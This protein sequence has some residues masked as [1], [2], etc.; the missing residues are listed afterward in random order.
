[1]RPDQKHRPSQRQALGFSQRRRPRSSSL[2]QR[3]D[4]NAKQGRPDGGYLSGSR[5]CHNGSSCHVCPPASKSYPSTCAGILTCRSRP[6]ILSRI[7]W[8]DPRNDPIFRQFLPLE[9]LMIPDHPKLTLDSLGETA[10]SPVPGLVHRYPD[11]ALFLGKPPCEN[12]S[13]SHAITPGYEW[14]DHGS[15]NLRLSDILHFLH[16]LLRRRCQH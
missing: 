10:D 1:M 6:Y 4:A 13:S 2:P 9:S 12:N 16:S 14:A 11:K 8:K 3:W 15:S 7:N 5:C